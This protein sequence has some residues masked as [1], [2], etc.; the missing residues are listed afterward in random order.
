MIYQVK[1]GQSISPND[2]IN[3]VE[4]FSGIVKKNPQPLSM[5]ISF[6]FL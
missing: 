5:Y 3:I 2:N 4:M 6:P 1:N